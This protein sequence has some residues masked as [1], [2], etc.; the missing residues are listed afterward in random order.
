MRETI[1]KKSVARII[2]Q[3][4][5]KL[6][7]LCKK[8]TLFRIPGAGSLGEWRTITSPYTLG[9]AMFLRSKYPSVIIANEDIRSA[10]NDWTYINENGVD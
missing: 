9:V 3:A 4:T 2:S 10:A 7:R 5:A 6:T 1:V 8:E